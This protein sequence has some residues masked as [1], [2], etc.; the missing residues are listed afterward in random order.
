MID[1]ISIQDHMSA[2]HDAVALSNQRILEV[3]GIVS[4]LITLLF[5]VIIAGLI[6]AVIRFFFSRRVP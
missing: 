4:S 2:L 1:P 5:I 3:A 6:L